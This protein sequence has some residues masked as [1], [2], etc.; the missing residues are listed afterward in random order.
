MV[1]IKSLNIP[2]KITVYILAEKHSPFPVIR[3]LLSWFPQFF[4]QINGGIERIVIQRGGTQV[5]FSGRKTIFQLICIRLYHT[6]F[7]QLAAGIFKAPLYQRPKLFSLLFVTSCQS[8]ARSSI[9]NHRRISPVSS[10]AP[11]GPVRPQA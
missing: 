3:Y 7:V 2:S 1:C 11:P 6:L 8:I 5:R 10:S 9:R 4:P